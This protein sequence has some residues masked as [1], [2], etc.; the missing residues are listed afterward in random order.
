MIGQRL[1]QEGSAWAEAW[2]FGPREDSIVTVEE[3]TRIAIAHWGSG[4]IEKVNNAAKPHE[5]HT[6]RLDWTKARERLHWDPLFDIE[7]SVALTVEWYKEVLSSRHSA[8]DVTGRQIE[9][10]IAGIPE[11][12]QKS[13]NA[14]RS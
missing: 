4:Q 3:L 10:Y 14:N 1:Y 13:T 8:R 12:L 2:N 9:S 7:Q 6:L 5:A 11:P